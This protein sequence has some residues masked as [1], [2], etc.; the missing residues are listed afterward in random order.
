MVVVSQGARGH[1]VARV[2]AA[3]LTA[4]AVAACVPAAAYAKPKPSAKQLKQELKQLEKESDGLIK[5][6]YEGRRTL[7]KAE[8]DERDAKKKL[9]ESQR[10]FDVAARE[11]RLIAAERHRSGGFEPNAALIG[12]NDPR[13]VLGQMAL[14]EQM[15][16]A[17]NA[18]LSSYTQIRDAHQQAQTEASQKTSDLRTALDTLEKQRKDAEKTIVKIKDRIDLLY[19]TPGMRPNGTFIPQL[20]GGPDNITPRMRLVRNLI[21]ERFGVPFGVGCYRA[22]ND[23]GEHP[24]GRACD[25]MLSHGG[26]MPGSREIQRGHDISNWVIKN[27]KRLGIMYVIYRQ[28]I[29]HVRTGSW[30]YMSDRGGATAN[31][32]DHP[33]ISVY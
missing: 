29:W 1:G 17:Q 6:Y 30:R 7:Q 33:H 13:A 21:V 25:F 12:G 23:G 9:G 14:A 20:P 18:R 22:I 19:P 8:K 3:S 27:A 15:V 28:R 2:L 32:Y 26:S 5:R 31:H 4:A 24:L 16:A 11:I 10:R